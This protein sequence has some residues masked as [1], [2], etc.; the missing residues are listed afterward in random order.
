[1]RQLEARQPSGVPSKAVFHAGLA[2][3]CPKPRTG[4]RFSL[5]FAR[6]RVLPSR[7]FASRAQ[8]EKTAIPKRKKIAPRKMARVVESEQ[9]VTV[10][11]IRPLISVRN[12]MLEALM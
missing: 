2:P 12:R 10:E 6:L 4:H 1:L 11:S 9:F 5:T 8:H 7:F 3:V